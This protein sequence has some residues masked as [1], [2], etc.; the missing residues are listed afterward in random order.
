MNWNRFFSAVSG[1]VLYFLV[2]ELLPEWN[3]LLAALFGASVYIAVAYLLPKS[4][5][6][7]LRMTI[8][9]SAVILMAVIIRLLS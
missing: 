7:S 8:S 9:I 1:A 5:K 4:M 3:N 6:E 2:T